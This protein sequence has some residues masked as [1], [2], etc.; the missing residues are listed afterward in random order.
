[1]LI[2]FSAK[3]SYNVSKKVM[4]RACFSAFATKKN[5]NDSMSLMEMGELKMER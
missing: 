5:C 3:N 1:M 4:G 2:G